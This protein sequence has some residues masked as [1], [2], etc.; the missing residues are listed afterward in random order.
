MENKNS[1][2]LEKALESRF[3][4]CEATE[5]TLIEDANLFT[6]GLNTREI[7]T[8][9]FEPIRWF[10]TK[11]EAFEWMLKNKSKEGFTIVET[12]HRVIR[13]IR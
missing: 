7:S 5:T 13:E 11:A 9:H 10:D 4:V 3:W 1:Q 2:R 8:L 6:G 12:F